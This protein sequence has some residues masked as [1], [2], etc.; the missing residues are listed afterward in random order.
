MIVRAGPEGRTLPALL[1]GHAEDRPDDPFAIDWEGTLTWGEAHEL[2]RRQSAGFA[3]LGVEAGDTVGIMLENRREFL[4]SW[5]GLAQMGAVEVPIDPRCRGERLAHVLNQSRCRE[6][7]VQ[8][9]CLGQVDSVADRVPALTRV[10]VVGDGR[11]E[12]VASI[13]FA[14]VEG[15]AADA[16]DPSVSFSDPIAVMFTS[17]SSGPAKGVVLSHGQHYVNG[18]HPVALFGIGRGDTLYVCLPL[19]HNMAQGYGVCVSLVSGAAVRI[20]PRFDPA[21]FWPDVRANGATILS[22]VGAMLVLLAK[23]QARDD[24]AEN[25]LRLGFGVPIPA[26]LHAEFERRFGLRLVHCYGSTEATIVA[27]NDH[28]GRK[29]GAVGRPLPDYDVRVM[30]EDDLPVPPG[31]RGEICVRPHEPFSMFSGYLGEPELTVSAWRNLWFHT[32]DRGWFDDDGDLW[33]SDRL[34][35]VVRHLGEMISPYE[36]EQALLTHPGV[37]MVAVYGVPS[38]LIEEELMAAVVPQPGTVLS[39]SEVRAWCR[40]RL[41][42]AAVPRFVELREEL[43]MTPSG[44]IEKFKLRERGVTDATDDVR[45]GMEALR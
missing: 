33:F 42:A 1:R 35:D 41:P 23:A 7:V 39:P 25:P 45:A 9:E 32:G 15:N 29:A 11:S 44:K 21:R 3:R 28:P 38:D 34:G 18:Y 12:R 16:P 4:A 43:P 5:L 31:V 13:P 24:D 20:A 14:E 22:F 30:G 36:V 37:Q 2:A 27:W 26:Q 6:L 8:A 19:H 17:G 40:E 10:L